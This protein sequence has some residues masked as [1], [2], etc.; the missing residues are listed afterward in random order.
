MKELG[1]PK[2]ERVLKRIDFLRLSKQARKVHTEHFIVMCGEINCVSRRIGITVSRKTGNA[3]E[4]NRTKRLIRE[5]FRLN[6]SL[7]LLADYN[8][9]A[10][11][12][13]AG[14]AIS[15]YVRELT[16]AL[17]RLGKKQCS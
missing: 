4:R 2:V 12:G 15:D 17:Q 14:L 7:F 8:V 5:F 1:F 10:K 9:I 6:K 16:I 3:V 13:V 11:P